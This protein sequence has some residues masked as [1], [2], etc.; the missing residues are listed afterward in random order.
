MLEFEELLPSYFRS[1]LRTGHKVVY[2]W[3]PRRIKWFKPEHESPEVL[4]QVF[5]RKKHQAEK[6]NGKH[7]KGHH[8]G[9]EH[10]H[11]HATE[12]AVRHAAVSIFWPIIIIIHIGGE[13]GGRG[14]E[15]A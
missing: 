6:H 4:Q 8:I 13:M 12:H 2:P 7:S 9:T 5:G 14:G 15:G 1:K 3:K 10:H 11:H